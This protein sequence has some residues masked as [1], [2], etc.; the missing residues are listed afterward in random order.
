[1][2]L[3]AGDPAGLAP[4]QPDG[5]EPVLV[6]RGAIDEAGGLARQVVRAHRWV[7]VT[8]DIVGPL[9]AGRVQRSFGDAHVDVL[10]I[11]AGEAH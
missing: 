1:M 9:Y 4:L 5:A 2:T 10:T 8:D 3:P 11:P 7:I 6:R